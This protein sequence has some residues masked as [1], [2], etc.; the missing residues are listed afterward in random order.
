MNNS[1][2]LIVCILFS[3]DPGDIKEGKYSRVRN[4]NRMSLGLKK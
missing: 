1:F 3:F 4:F 2:S